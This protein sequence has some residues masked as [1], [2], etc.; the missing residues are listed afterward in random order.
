MAW[1]Y[2]LYRISNFFNKVE[3]GEND[4]QHCKNNTEHK[5]HKYLT[6]GKTKSYFDLKL[7]KMKPKS[8]LRK[9]Y[10]ALYNARRI[11]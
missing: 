1:K 2:S 4:N 6:A 3:L 9:K 11:F 7:N 8:Q 10:I 5:P